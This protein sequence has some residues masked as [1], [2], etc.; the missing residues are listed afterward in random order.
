MVAP[1]IIA[2]VSARR[3]MGPP[4]PLRACRPAV[5]EG[6]GRL[7]ARGRRRAII[8]VPPSEMGGAG[9]SRTALASF[10]YCTRWRRTAS[11]ARRRRSTWTNRTTRAPP[12]LFGCTYRPRNS[13]SRT[14]NKA[15]PGS[16]KRSRGF[17]SQS[18]RGG[19]TKTTSARTTTSTTARS[20]GGGRGR[21]FF[22]PPQ[23]D[24][25][26]EMT[27]ASRDAGVGSAFEVHVVMSF[28]KVRVRTMA[29]TAKVAS[30]LQS[31]GAA[32]SAR[33]IAK[34]IGRRRLGGPSGRVPAEAIRAPRDA[35]S[36]LAGPADPMERP[37]EVGPT[38][39]GKPPPLALARQGLA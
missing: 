36:T 7:S 30:P 32:G 6:I 9:F 10:R 23:T 17:G 18:L 28:L 26:I 3:A 33:P 14:S 25:F 16:N 37:R 20:T 39:P 22:W 31:H 19:Y 38:T 29:T 8:A 27:R 5:G 21:T 1:R 12:T 4:P 11:G 2:V 24:F 34:A 15:R 13:R 35:S